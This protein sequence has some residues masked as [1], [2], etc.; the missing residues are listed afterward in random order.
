VTEV[1]DEAQIECVARLEIELSTRA[2]LVLIVERQTRVDVLDGAVA[3]GVK[4]GQPAGQCTARANNTT[5]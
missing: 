5:A 2:D 3:A 4:S 1:C